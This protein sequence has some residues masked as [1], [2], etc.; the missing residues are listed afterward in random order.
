MLPGMPLVDV[1]ALSMTC[2]SCIN[3]LPNTGVTQS[4]STYNVPAQVGSATI[5]NLGAGQTETIAVTIVYKPRSCVSY[6]SD[7]RQT[8]DIASYE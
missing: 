1:T 8:E 7:N 2:P 5:Q 3:N 6:Q 4:L